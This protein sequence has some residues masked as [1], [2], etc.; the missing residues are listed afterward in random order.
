MTKIIGVRF[1]NVGK[2]YYFNPKN[3]DIKNGDNVI[4]ETARG[5]EY[6]HVVLGPKE[7]DSSQV[8]QPLKDVI[9]IATQRTARKRKTTEEKK[10][11]PLRSARKR[12][13]SMIW[14]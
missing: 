7:V 6:G 9:R 8:V 12:L 5:V 10:R 3:L 13:K 2:V 4:V 11:K 14:R 1:R